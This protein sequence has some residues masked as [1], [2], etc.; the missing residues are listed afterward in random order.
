VLHGS[1]LKHH[2]DPVHSHQPPDAER[3]HDPTTTARAGAD[4]VLP[5]EAGLDTVTSQVDLDGALLS[6]SAVSAAD[7]WAVGGTLV[8]HFN[9]TIWSVVASANAPAS[10]GN[11]NGLAGVTALA[12]GAVVAVGSSTVDNSNGTSTNHPLIIQ[13]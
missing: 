9:G 13:N 12:D 11:F 10:A 2:H 5:V 7:V 1:A 6:T 8:E 3:G 4:A